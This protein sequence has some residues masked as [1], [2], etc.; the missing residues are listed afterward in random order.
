MLKFVEH[1]VVFS[2]I[3]DEITLAVNVSNCPYHC[4][5]CHS[6]H[7]WGDTGDELNIESIS[8]LIDG[9]IHGITCV[10]LM[11][12]GNDIG[13]VCKLAKEVKTKYPSLKFALYTGA[14]A[15]PDVD[16]RYFDYI[17]IGPYIEECGP[18]NKRTTNQRLYKV[19]DGKL[20]DITGM[21]WRDDQ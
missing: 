3:P 8:R 11:G 4:Q 16:L 13:S 21:F 1:L 14:S 18:L 7:L 19:T 15:V 12:D 2:E 5:G 10:C 9:K 17:K 6:K 20:E